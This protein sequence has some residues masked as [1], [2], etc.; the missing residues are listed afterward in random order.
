[1]D[2]DI[3]ISLSNNSDEESCHDHKSDDSSHSEEESKDH[4]QKLKKCG[5]YFEIASLT[6]DEIIQNIEKE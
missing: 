3:S 5:M 2:S 4:V 1:M 6:L